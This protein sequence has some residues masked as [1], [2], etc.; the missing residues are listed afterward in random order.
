VIRDVVVSLDAR[1]FYGRE[2]FGPM[3]GYITVYVLELALLFAALAAIGP[4][5]RGASAAPQSP[6]TSSPYG[7]AQFPG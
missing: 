2:S 5:V 7:L 3:S 1:G 6:R 4:L